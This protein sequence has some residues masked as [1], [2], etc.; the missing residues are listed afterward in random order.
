MVKLDVSL[1]RFMEDEDF[2]VLTALEMTMR[3]H[4]VA[5]TA[6]IERIAQ[7]PHGGCKKRLSELL[8]KKMI[9]HENTMYDGYSMKYAAYDYLAMRALS[10]RGAV[11]GVGSRIGCGKESDII[12]VQ[13]EAGNDCVMKLQRLGRCSFR[14]VTRN[15][16]YKGGKTRR[17]ESWF[18]L[19]RLAA[20]KEFA[21]M[22]MLYD[23]GF[24]VP[25]P[26]DQNRHAVVMELVNGTL[27]NH[28]QEM[29][30]AQ[31][32]Y[33]RCLA[34]MVRLAEHGLIHGD[35][36][37]FN[38]MITDDLRVIMIDFPQMISTDHRNASELFDRDVQNLAN[39]FSRRFRIPT[40]LYPK[41]EADVERQGAL[42]RQAFASGFFTKKQQQELENL[43]EEGNDSDDEDETEEEG[44]DEQSDTEAPTEGCDA[45]HHEDP[46]PEK[47]EE[48]SSDEETSDADELEGQIAEAKEVRQHQLRR[49]VKE[50]PN[51]VGKGSLNYDY[52]K[53]RVKGIAKRADDKDF[54]RNLHR[55][56]QK[57]RAK[58]KIQRE[59]KN[60]G[61]DCTLFE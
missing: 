32:V 6:L 48:T 57:G 27:L 39:F 24:P 40:L 38:I 58:R 29:E 42:D 21:F 10:K 50:N 30:Q 41:L 2:R 31:K 26:I 45:Q 14:T 19:S 51:L 43:L 3:N 9:H 23:E 46:Q 44:E 11:T 54:N 52:I 20:Q 34:L 59:L 53:E 8:K 25:K 37:E 18:Y 7:L 13:D 36:N 60:H 61:R 22:K 33:E 28:I 47:D 17:G 15:R 49:S 56:A 16:D 12:L 35:F 5:P 4:D 1:L 55:N